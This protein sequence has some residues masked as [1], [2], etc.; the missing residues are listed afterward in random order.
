MAAMGIFYHNPR[1][2][3]DFDLLDI[4]YFLLNCSYLVLLSFVGLNFSDAFLC[5]RS[6]RHSRECLRVQAR[7]QITEER[8]RERAREGA[9]EGE[10]DG[11]R[12]GE[13]G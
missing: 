3:S 4:F 12:E 1:A 13:R 11:E 7:V 9:R 8:E 2:G 6:V 10:V 5:M